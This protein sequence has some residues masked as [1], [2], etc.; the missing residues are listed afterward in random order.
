MSTHGRY[1]DDL[2]LGSEDPNRPIECH[3]TKGRSRHNFLKLIFCRDS[4]AD[5]NTLRITYISLVRPILKHGLF[6]YTCASKSNLDKLERVQL[7]AAEIISRIR[8]SCLEDIALLENNLL[9]LYR[10]VRRPYCLTKVSNKLSSFSDQHSTF[11]Y[12]CDCTDN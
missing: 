5:V 2:M 10:Y 9:S 1:Y 4:G 7:S 6:L 11:A 8:H 3:V 12:F